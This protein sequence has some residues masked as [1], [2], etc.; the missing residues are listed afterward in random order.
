M[1]TDCPQYFRVR[2]FILL[3]RNK[4]P[5]FSMPQLLVILKQLGRQSVLFNDILHSLHRPIFG[6]IMQNSCRFR[7]NGIGSII[8]GQLDR[9]LHYSQRMLPALVWHL[10][11]D[12]LNQRFAAVGHTI[13]SSAHIHIPAQ[14]PY[15]GWSGRL[16]RVT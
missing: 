14:A 16:P 9:S 10:G 13:H 12:C 15:S 11:G 2:N 5:Y 1:V 7:L 3:L 6:Y 4:C 8:P